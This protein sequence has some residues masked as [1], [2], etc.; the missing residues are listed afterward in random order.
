MCERS[1][2]TPGVLTTSYRA[3]SS[4]SWQF[5]S[6]RD[7]GW[8]TQAISASSDEL[9]GIEGPT[10]LSNATGGTSNYGLDHC[11]D[12][13]GVRRSARNRGGVAGLQV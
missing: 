2:A 7:S 5:L 10:H 12:V 13:C 1:A 6:S 4:T 9:A 11:D 3:S 8:Q